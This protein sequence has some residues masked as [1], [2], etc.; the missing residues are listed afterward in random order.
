MKIND[1]TLT[2]A[3]SAW[4][5]SRCDEGTQPLEAR[6]DGA[7]VVVT[8]ADGSDLS[9]TEQVHVRGTV[10]AHRAEPLRMPSKK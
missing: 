8:R 10:A 7:A 1:L 4:L 6:Q 9:V 5:A 3:L 2:P